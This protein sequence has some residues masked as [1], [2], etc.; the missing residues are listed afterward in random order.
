MNRDERIFI[1]HPDIEKLYKEMILYYRKLESVEVVSTVR[2]GGSLSNTSYAHHS[3]SP[4]TFT[5]NVLAK[6]DDVSLAS[7]RHSRVLSGL[8][9][10]A[11]QD[12]LT[13]TNSG[14][15]PVVTDSSVVLASTT[16]MNRTKR[17]NSGLIPYMPVS[18]PIPVITKR[19]SVSKLYHRSK[20][21]SEAIELPIEEEES[22][23]PR[24]VM[25]GSIGKFV[26]LFSQKEKK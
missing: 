17:S 11:P 20:E 5:S 2:P 1:P 12:K 19:N 24:R 25:S 7:D 15:L 10:N 3:R 9:V 22:D 18:E 16:T 6:E 26:N 8:I 23:K 4:R 21:H 14:T 13:R